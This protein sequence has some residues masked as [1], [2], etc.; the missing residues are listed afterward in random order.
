MYSDSIREQISHGNNLKH[1][2]ESSK[3]RVIYDKHPLPEPQLGIR[4][5]DSEPLT[6]DS[7]V[8]IGASQ[9]EVPSLVMI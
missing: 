6:S 3:Q 2:Y 4:R 7:A 1:R 5:S 9:N 8:E